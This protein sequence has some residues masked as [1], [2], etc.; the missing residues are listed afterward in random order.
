VTTTK[1]SDAQILTKYSLLLR[2]LESMNCSGTCQLREPCGYS[3]LLLS[4][5]SFKNR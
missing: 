3:V 2:R 4:L 5:K 1:S